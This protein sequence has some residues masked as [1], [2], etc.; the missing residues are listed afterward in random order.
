MELDEFKAYR[1]A[2]QE[3]EIEQQNLTTENLNNIIMKT[4]DILN[5]LHARNTRSNRW[6]KIAY[7]ILISTVFFQIAIGLLLNGPE[8]FTKSIPFYLIIVLLIASATWVYRVQERAFVILKN[9][10]LKVSLRKTVANFKRFYIKYVAI[11]LFLLPATFYTGFGDLTR[12]F[13][14][15]QDFKIITSVLFTF[16]TLVFTHIYFKK[17]YFSRI[18]EMETHLKELEEE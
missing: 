13:N 5:E 10:N 12:V 17:K 14:I 15:S 7:A 1:K 3:K 6:I 2:A 8:S 11:Y 16:F 4:T 18:A 9:E